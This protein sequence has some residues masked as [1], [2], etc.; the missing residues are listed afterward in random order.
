MT[1]NDRNAMQAAREA[2]NERFARWCEANDV[3]AYADDANAR[4]DA[5]L[6]SLDD[7]A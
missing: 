6:A 2:D 5:Y 1:D 7:D 3:D 4:Y